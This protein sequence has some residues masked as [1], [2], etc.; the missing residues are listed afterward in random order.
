MCCLRIDRGPR[1][2]HL[3]SMRTRA[4][5][6]FGMLGAGCS[7]D[8]TTSAGG[9]GAA[10][11]APD[12]HGVRVGGGETSD[13]GNGT[14]E[15]YGCRSVETTE[16]GVGEAL[17]AGLPIDGIIAVLA[18]PFEAPGWRARWVERM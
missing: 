8:D 4:L 2:W 13:F 5:L 10:R 11:L 14:S 6:F 3:H 7:T 18:E 1:A 17:A 12:E 9:E 15:P 16:L